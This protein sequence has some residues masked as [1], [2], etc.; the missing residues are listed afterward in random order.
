MITLEIIEAYQTLV[1]PQPLEETAKTALQQQSAPE[2]ADLTIVITDD[3][4]LRQLNHAYRDIDASTDVLSFPADF[5]DPESDLPYLGD[6]LISFERA[7]A[8]AAAAGHATIAE[9]QLLVTHGVLHLLGHDHADPAEKARM[10]SAQS[11]ILRQLGL[12]NL[13]ITGDE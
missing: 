1:A 8:Q 11:E 2:D 5:T 9:L 3:E 13:P 7:E 4:Q 6:I 10:W 12:E